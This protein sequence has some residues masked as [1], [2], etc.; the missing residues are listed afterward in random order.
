MLDDLRKS[1]ADGFEEE[2]ESFV[3]AEEDDLTGGTFLGMT[4]VER[5]LLSI[6]MFLLVTAIGALLLIVTNRVV[7]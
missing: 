4:A 2:E 1:A 7:L 5:M 3:E 6:L